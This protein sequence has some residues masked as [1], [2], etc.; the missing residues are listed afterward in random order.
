MV[1]LG[2]TRTAVGVP[3]AW[4]DCAT[5]RSCWTSICIILCSLAL[6]RFNSREPR[7]TRAS[8][9]LPAY[10]YCQR[11]IS[12]ISFV[13]GLQ[14]GSEKTNRTGLLLAHKLES[15]IIF[16]SGPCPLK[17]GAGVPIGS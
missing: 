1:P 3:Y 17:V 13:Q 7:L 15:V 12:D 6:T 14:L 10:S 2:R 16:P 9:S 11:L 4:Y 5:S 8:V